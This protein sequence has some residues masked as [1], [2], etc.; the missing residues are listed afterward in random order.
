MA[1]Y[2]ATDANSLNNAVQSAAAGDTIYVMNNISLDGDGSGFSG[3]ITVPAVPG[4]SVVTIES[5]GGPFTISST[6]ANQRHFENYGYLTLQN[7]ILDG[8]NTGGGVQVNA[9]TTGTTPAYTETNLLGG[10]VIQNCSTTAIGGG[11]VDI[12]TAD[13]INGGYDGVSTAS[14]TMDG[15]TIQNNHQR[16]PTVAGGGVWLSG[17]GVTAT[18]NNTNGTTL[19]DSNTSQWSGGGIVVNSGSTLTIDNGTITNNQAALHGGGIDMFNGGYG[20]TA[21]P[22]TVIINN[23]LIMGNAAGANVDGMGKPNSTSPGGSG[24]GIANEENNILQINGGTIQNN[25]ATLNGGGISSMVDST[26]TITGTTTPSTTLPNPP[27]SGSPVVVGNTADVNGGGISV[28]TKSDGSAYTDTQNPTAQATLTDVAILSN[29]ADVDGGG[30]HVCDNSLVTASG[31]L[32]D[33]NQ[34]TNDGGGY[35]VMQ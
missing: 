5:N 12:Q 20:S 32:F 35:Y 25:T 11:G 18:M 13:A 10:C 26:L 6:T 7:I 30:L 21:P 8:G 23:A 19:I 16:T 17:Q 14:L 33:S 4:T 9:D 3:T 34:A 29:I 24:G 1:T 22:A 31:N 2:N 28:G 15:C 27:A